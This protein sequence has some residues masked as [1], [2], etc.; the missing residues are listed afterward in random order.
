MDLGSMLS[1]IVHYP[2]QR[3]SV[4]DSDGSIEEGSKGLECCPG[5]SGERGQGF[6]LVFFFKDSTNQ[7][8]DL[9]WEDLSG[10]SAG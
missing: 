1:E 3:V 10:G 2:R 7:E 5:S 4:G 8:E 6:L 9:G